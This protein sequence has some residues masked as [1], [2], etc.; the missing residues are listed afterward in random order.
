MLLR[1]RGALDPQQESLQ[2][3]PRSCTKAQG[4]LSGTQERVTRSEAYEPLCSPFTGQVPVE[5]V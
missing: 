5:Q 1:A 2:S 3:T 4:L